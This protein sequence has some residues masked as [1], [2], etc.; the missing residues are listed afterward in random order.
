MTEN[1][2]EVYYSTLDLFPQQTVEH[3][4]L[5]KFF[6]NLR[7]GMLTTSQCEECGTVP[8][9]PRT[10]CPSC[11]SDK[12]RWIELPSRGKVDVFTVQ[13]AGHP[14]VLDTPLI[15]AMVSLP[16]APAIVARIVDTAPD[17]MEDGCEVELVVLPVERD[18]V[19]YAFRKVT[20]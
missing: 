7:G 6:D 9:P 17:E 5:Y 15:L 18:R 14:P 13:W 16:G 11:F 3:N 4:K 8:W 1:A 19:T 20:Q 12:L 2:S 10:V